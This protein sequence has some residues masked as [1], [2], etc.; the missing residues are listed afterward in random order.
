MVFLFLF[1]NHSGFDHLFIQLDVCFTQ[2]I[3][4]P[5][6]LVI[7]MAIL[8]TE[9]YMLVGLTQMSARMNLGKPLPNMAILLQ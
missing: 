6:L 5:R 2:V 9:R 1:C 3:L 4:A 7:Q 8:L